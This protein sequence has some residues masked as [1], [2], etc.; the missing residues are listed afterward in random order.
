MPQRYSL[1]TPSERRAWIVV[2]SNKSGQ[3]QPYACK[4]SLFGVHFR[5]TDESPMYA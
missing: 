2:Y 1:T 5:E 4:P 3:H